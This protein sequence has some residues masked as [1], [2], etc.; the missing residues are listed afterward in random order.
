MRKCFQIGLNLVAICSI[1]AFLNPWT[2]APS[3]AIFIV[4]FYMRKIFLETSRD[5]K[6]VESVSK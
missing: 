4:A 6:R 3:T 5:V 2:L 1:I